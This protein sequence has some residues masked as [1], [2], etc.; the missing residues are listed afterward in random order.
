MDAVGAAQ[1]RNVGTIVDN[2]DRVSGMRQPNDR[3]R[4]VEQRRARQRF[5]A[6]LQKPRA[7]VEERRGECRD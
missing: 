7:A 4:C 3:R 6:E 1:P 5:R 2:D